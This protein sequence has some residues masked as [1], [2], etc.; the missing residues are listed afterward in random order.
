[1]ESTNNI[2]E[3]LWGERNVRTI[4]MRVWLSEVWAKESMWGFQFVLLYR[5][6][7]RAVARQ[8]TRRDWVRWL[9]SRLFQAL[10]YK[11]YLWEC[12]QLE[13]VH[14]ARVV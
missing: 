5:I 7:G 9:L 14:N 3:V 2:A 12:K 6:F 1:M 10:D 4:R 13:I 11:A 8:V